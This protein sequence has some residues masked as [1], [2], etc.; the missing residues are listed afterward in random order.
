MGTMPWVMSK[1]NGKQTYVLLR[2]ELHQNKVRQ[3]PYCVLVEIIE[4]EEE[5]IKSVCKDCPAAADLIKT[6]AHVFS[7]VK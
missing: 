3:K 5:I 2:V 6:S 1:L 4:T 7:V